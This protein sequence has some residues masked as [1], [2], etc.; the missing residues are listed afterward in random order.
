MSN[1]ESDSK[2]M[3]KNCGH[4]IESH[5]DQTGKCMGEMDKQKEEHPW[6]I[7]NCQKFWK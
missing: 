2:K 5:Q 4:G 3:C 1:F 7:A 6:C